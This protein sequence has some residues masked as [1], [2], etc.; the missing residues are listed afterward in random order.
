VLT[1]HVHCFFGLRNNWRSHSSPP[2]LCHNS[3]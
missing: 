3:R 2:L 1:L